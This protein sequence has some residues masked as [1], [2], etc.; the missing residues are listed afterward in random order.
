MLVPA[1][2][3]E[4]IAKGRAEERALKSRTL[5]PYAGLIFSGELPGEPDWHWVATAPES[6]ILRWAENQEDA[7][8]DEDVDESISE[9]R[10]QKEEDW[11]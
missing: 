4:R 10:H 8:R 11:Q 7:L 6:E 5:E 3:Q 1:D 2:D 9:G